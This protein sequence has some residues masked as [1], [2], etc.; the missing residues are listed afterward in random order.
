MRPK[1]DDELTAVAEEFE[2]TGLVWSQAAVQNLI[3]PYP[4]R[5]KADA[6]LAKLGED[7]YH[8]EVHALDVGEG[9]TLE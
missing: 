9:I 8:D 2:S 7:F 3:L 6:I 5:K 1:I 4:R